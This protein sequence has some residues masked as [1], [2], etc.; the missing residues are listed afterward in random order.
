MMGDKE[1]SFCPP[2]FCY[3]MKCIGKCIALVFW[4]LAP[5]CELIFHGLLGGC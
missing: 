3:G 4:V 2:L 1:P 5:A